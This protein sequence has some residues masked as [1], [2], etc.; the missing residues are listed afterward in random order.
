MLSDPKTWA[1][2]YGDVLDRYALSRVGVPGL[3][4]VTRTDGSHG[5]WSTLAHIGINV[6]D[7]RAGISVRPGHLDLFSAVR[8]RVV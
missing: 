8:R 2:R 1:D 7:T 5:S 3:G 4:I 6:G